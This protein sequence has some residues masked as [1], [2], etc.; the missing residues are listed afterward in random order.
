MPKIDCKFLKQT[1]STIVNSTGQ[2]WP[3]CYFGNHEHKPIEYN[4]EKDQHIFKEYYKNKDKQNLN[5]HTLKEILNN[6]W[7]TKTL[8]ESWKDEKTCSRQC[9]NWCT[10]GH[11][12]AELRI[13]K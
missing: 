10:K 1:T 3:C 8:P 11:D 4:V 2:V 9:K 12:P 5:N 6:E 13:K 7:F